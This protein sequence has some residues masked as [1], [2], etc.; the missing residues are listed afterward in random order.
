[1]SRPTAISPEEQE[2]IARQIGILLLQNA[3]EDWQEITV[4]Y[5]ATGEY[6]DLLGEITSQDGASRAWDPPNELQSI[7]ERLREGM[8]RPDVGTWL[9]ALYVVERPSSYRID[10]NFD[11]EPRWQRPLP[12]AA[13]LDEL[14][15]YPRTEEN[16]PDWMRAIIDGATQRN[17]QPA[18]DAPAPGPGAQPE[19]GYAPAAAEPAPTQPT[20]DEPGPTAPPAAAPDPVNTAEPDPVSTAET[21]SPAEPAAETDL[22][23]A[24]AQPAA[25]EEPVG[26]AP[27]AE[28]AAD[29]GVPATPPAPEE[30]RKVEV[31]DGTD[32]EGRPVVGNRPPVPMEEIGAL[33][34]Y[35][36]NAPIVF[37]GPTNLPDQLDSSRPAS[38]PDTWHTDG[39][40]LWPGAVGYYLSQYGVPPEPEFLDHLRARRFELPEVSEQARQA[41]QIAATTTTEQPAETDEQPTGA[42]EQPVAE[43]VAETAIGAAPQDAPEEAPAPQQ[44]EE[45]TAET[46]EPEPQATDVA[47]AEPEPQ[48]ADIAELEPEVPASAEPELPDT[49]EVPREEREKHEPVDTESAAAGEPV[50]AAEEP[51]PAVE[52]SAQAEEVLDVLRAR[53]AEHQVAED[54][55]R[56]GSRDEDALSLVADGAEWVVA[57]AGEP[58][59]RFARAEQAAAYLLGSLLLNKPAAAQPAVE[60]PEETSAAVAEQPESVEPAAANEPAEPAEP[61]EPEERSE[62]AA[63]EAAQGPAEPQAPA[64]PKPSGN[65]LFTAHQEPTD[66]PS[67]PPEPPLPPEPPA[68]PAAAEE[69]AGFQGGF[70]QQQPERPAPAGPPSPPMGQPAAPRPGGPAGGAATP[71]PL[72]KRQPRTPEGAPVPPPGAPQ[73]GPGGAD[74]RPG[75]GVG[76]GVPPR[77]QGPVPP[78]P[79]RPQGAPQGPV[80]PPKQIQPLN[81]E[82]PLTLYRDRRHIML[83]PGT[84]VDRFGEPNGNVVYAARTPYSHRSLPPQWAN[85]PYFAYRVQRPMQALRGTA[86]PW[87]D[88]PGGGTA[89]VLPA[90]ISELLAD[91]SL[92]ELPANEAPWPT[93]E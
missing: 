7:F 44:P 64:E 92:V 1:M 89:Y 30:F 87:F 50:E 70:Q 28:P 39:S 37:T 38:V 58:E 71:P 43:P 79:P 69:P 47:A 4:E 61:A 54:S 59:V 23:A 48:P 56:I 53:L 85:R 86:V 8:Y 72:P 15:R 22:P 78:V 82:P 80:Q 18:G 52:D 66:A 60:E 21:A 67:A 46:A 34:N 90:S 91:G 20:T 57:R 62:P 16:I 45:P 81:G 49:P 3:P 29:S 10:I 77:P 51:Q 93:M 83:Q 2:Q 17:E 13:Y 11:S 5:R 14:Q 33:R 27:T 24:D 31:F 19:P 25:P 88:Q 74:R 41:A 32:A 65:P 76:P 36:E 26:E 68:A 73:P 42:A 75:P 63:T 55:Y 84:E 9:S 40:W 6:R 12:P 35:L